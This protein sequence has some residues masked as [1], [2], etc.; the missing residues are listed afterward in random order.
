MLLLPSHVRQHFV[1]FLMTAIVSTGGFLFG[2]DTCIIAG[3][4]I[5]IRESFPLNLFLQSFIVSS[6]VLGALMGS[7]SSGRLTQHYGPTRMLFMTSVLFL[8]ATFFS[9]IAINPVMLISARFLVGVAIGM[10]SYL[11]PLLIA[12]MAPA[13]LRGRLVL[14][15]GLMIATGQVTAFLVSYFLLTSESWRFM[16]LTG[17][18]PAFILFL[19][20][21]FL[22]PSPRTQKKTTP[23]SWQTLFSKKFQ[24]LLFIG[25]GLGIFQQCVGI[26]AIMY[27][28]PIIFA[29]IG[30]KSISETLI[31][32]LGLGFVNL[33]ATLIAYWF[34]D[35]YGRRLLLFIG[36]SI[37]F[38][39]LFLI[40]LTLSTS[41]ISSFSIIIIYIEML[42]F[43]AGYALSLGT[44]F[45]L[46]IS[47]IYPLNI[48]S[49]AMSFVT[50]VQWLACFLVTTSFLPLQN[51]LGTAQVFY[52]FAFMCFLSIIFSYYFVPETKGMSLEQIEINLLGETSK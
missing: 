27:F 22:P 2:Y 42:V 34:I 43:I 19:G 44:L 28:A 39:A 20:M 46:I 50:A 36:L 47:E 12:E 11:S 23:A 29:D 52:L 17:L 1:L 38:I 24:P 37:A 32:T 48:R 6:V 16:F 9:A 13:H 33:L 31:A 45:W 41:S 5:F 49:L 15:N 3:A 51:I 18:V 40:G 26:N 14:L 7:L 10:V 25:L 35:R 30:L 21:F 4:L 8:I